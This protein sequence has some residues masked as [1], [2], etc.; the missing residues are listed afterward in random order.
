MALERRKR[1]ARALQPELVVFS[2]ELTSASGAFTATGGDKSLVSSITDVGT[3]ELT[4]NLSQFGYALVGASVTPI[5][6]SPGTS[7]CGSAV[8][9]AYS[10]TAK[11]V[12]IACLK[13][14]GAVVDLDNGDK[15][16]VT[17]LFNDSY[18]Q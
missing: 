9:K 18:G 7:K 12:T 17:L 11:T 3:G 10:S 1:P 5:V 6:A 13:G 2:V 15:L 8:V 14:D 16:L 4:L